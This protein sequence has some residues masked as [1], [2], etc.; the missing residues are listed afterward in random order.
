M[1]K[2]TTLGPRH[3]T[4]LHPANI[5]AVTLRTHM[6][7]LQKRASSAPPLMETV[8]HI[9]QFWRRSLTF[10]HSGAIVHQRELYK[11]VRAYNTVLQAEASISTKWHDQ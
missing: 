6:P 1:P 8:N 9:L 11:H 5:G 10:D 2:R 4:R 3:H 7:P